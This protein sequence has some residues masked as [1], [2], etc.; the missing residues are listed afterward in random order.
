MERFR[1]ADHQFLKVRID[2]EWDYGTEPFR[3]ERTV[4]QQAPRLLA[5][6]VQLLNSGVEHL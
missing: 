1:D 4:L 5:S 2:L 3:Q 6:N